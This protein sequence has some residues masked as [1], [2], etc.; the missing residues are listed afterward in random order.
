MFYFF[1]GS[2][3]HGSYRNKTTDRFRR[4][5]ICHYASESTTKIG[6]FYSPLYR[7]NGEEVRPEINQDSGPC[8]T[9]FEDV[10]PH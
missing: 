1:N 6:Q 10:Y 2:L 5:F 7:E 8:G 4:A 9:E 3:I